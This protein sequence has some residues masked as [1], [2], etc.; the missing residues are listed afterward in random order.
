MK[1]IKLRLCSHCD[2]FSM[3]QLERLLA[4][5]KEIEIVAKCNSCGKDNSKLVFVITIP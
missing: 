5:T 4:Y 2:V 1:G 3:E